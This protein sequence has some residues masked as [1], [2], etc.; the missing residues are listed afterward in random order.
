VLG[1][2]DVDFLERVTLEACENQHTEEAIVG[3]I[4]ALR[5]MQA[6]RVSQ[7]IQEAII[8]EERNGEVIDHLDEL[9]RKKEA[10]RR[11]QFS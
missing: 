7:E 8:Q 3:S 5:N 10:L 6:D 1:P 4:S 2:S 11:Q 9:L